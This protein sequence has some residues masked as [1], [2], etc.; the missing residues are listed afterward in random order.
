LAQGNFEVIGVVQGVHEIAVERMDVL[1][2][3]K[4]I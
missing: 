2:S 1:E 4:A 3:G